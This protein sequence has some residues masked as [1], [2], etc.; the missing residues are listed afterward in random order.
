MG[1]GLLALILPNRE[2]K[3]MALAVLAGLLALSVRQLRTGS[4]HSRPEQD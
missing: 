1:F 2:A 4:R 3:L